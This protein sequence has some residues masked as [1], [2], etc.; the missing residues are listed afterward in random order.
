[1]KKNIALIVKI[2]NFIVMGIQ[3]GHYVD[4]TKDQLETWIVELNTYIDKNYDN[5]TLDAVVS[6]LE[7]TR[8]EYN[9]ESSPAIDLC[10]QKVI[11]MKKK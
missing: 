8:K 7:S 4:S 2:L 6:V 11:N 10:I 1:M 9:R 3:D 5:D